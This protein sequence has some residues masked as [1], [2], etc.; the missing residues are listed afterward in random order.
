[1]IKLKPLL[2]TMLVACISASWGQSKLTLHPEQSNTKISKDIY[3]HFA[4]HLGHCI[5]GGIYVGE[6]SEISNVRGFR[7]DVIGALKEMK[8][9]VLRWPG[10][11]FADTYHWKDGIGPRENRPSIVNVNWGNVTEDNSFGTHEFLDFC[12]LIDADAYIN[13]NVGSGT[14]QEASEWVEYVTSSNLSPMTELRKKNG[15]EEPWNVKYWGIGN[16]NWGCG[17]NMSPEYYAD[18]YKRFATFTHGNLYKIACGP[19]EGDYNWMDVVMQKTARNRGLM[20]GISLHKYTIQTRNWGDKGNA[21]GFGEK[22]WFETLHETLDMETLVTR[23]STIMD[24]YDPGKRVGLIVDEWGNWFN[25][26][27]GTNPGFLYQQNSLRDALVAGVNLN[28]FNN[29]AD[30]VKMANIAQMVNV[31]QAVILTKGDEMVLTPTYYVFKMYNVHQDANLVPAHIE[32]GKYSYEG[33]S[34]PKV[35][36]SSSVKDGVL[37]VTLCNLDPNNS[38]QVEI[39][40]PGNEYA[41]ATGQIVTAEQLND[42]NDFGKNEKVSIKAFSVVKPKGGKLSVNLPSKSVVLV[43]LQ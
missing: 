20:Q 13:I 16:E 32:T 7:D 36:A 40:I 17:G 10:G 31:L 28:I 25:V 41:S 26:E 24:K 29:H 33:K 35:H 22:E 4:E 1:M 19:S 2:I 21:T 18:L 11:C 3:G 39:V 34:V 30:R 38:E 6:D 42:Y 27:E 37:S 23:H 9:P 12:E 5:Y 14:V 43:Q 8:I 15:R